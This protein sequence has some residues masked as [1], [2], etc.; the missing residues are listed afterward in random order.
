MIG[1][2][3]QDTCYHISRANELGPSETGKWHVEIARIGIKALDNERKAA[4]LSADL[5]MLETYWREHVE[6]P[7]VELTHAQMQAR[8]EATFSELIERL[9]PD[10]LRLLDFLL[11]GETYFEEP[12]ESQMRE[13]LWE[14]GQGTIKNMMLLDAVWISGEGVCKG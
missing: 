9:R 5:D 14:Y 1:K 11:I 10:E 2:L 6:T 12:D 8:I 13:E 7:K 4:R 3:C